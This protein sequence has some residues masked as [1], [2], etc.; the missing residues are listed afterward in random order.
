MA[1]VGRSGGGKSTLL[2]LLTRSYEPQSGSISVDGQDIQDV[3]RASLVRHM[4]I[5]SPNVGVLNKSVLENL[6][7]AKPGASVQEC[8]D[9]CKAACLHQKITK[10]FD[11]G[12][13]EAIGRYK[14]SNGEAQRLAIARVLL[15]DSQIV[16]LDEATSNLDSE[17]EYKIQKHLREWCAGRTVVVI[18]H[19]LATIASADTILAVKDGRI[20]EQGPL[21]ELLANKGYFYELWDRQRSGFLAN[22]QAV[23]SDS[24]EEARAKAAARYT[25]PTSR[26]SLS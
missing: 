7:Y 25:K 1:I 6:R 23:E 20:V 12:Y 21:A 11:K 18:T 14:F 16:L 22:S 8:E 4:S 2:K 13:D 9:V 26:K 17:T 24:D 15:R 3:R 19:R 10:S 5:A